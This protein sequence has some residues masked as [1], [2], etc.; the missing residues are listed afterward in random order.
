VSRVNQRGFT[1]LELLVALVVL[2]L[3]VATAYAGLRSA[4][5]SWERAETRIQANE[6]QRAVTRFLRRT[7]AEITPLAHVEQGA[8]TV[9]FEGTNERLVFTSTLPALAAPG[10]VQEMALAVDRDEASGRRGLVLTWQPLDPESE[11]GDFDSPSRT[12]YLLAEGVEN[13]SIDYFGA[14]EEQEDARWHSNWAA[15]RRMPT[16]VRLVV[17]RRQQHWPVIVARV[18]SDSIRFLRGNGRF[19]PGGPSG[20]EPREIDADEDETGDDDQTP[21][22]GNAGEADS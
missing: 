8:W 14:R 20:G 13:L 12:S 7:F 18:R 6:D 15:Q 1:L 4:A 22:P 21:L 3:L 19:S 2:G 17:E 11:P 10:G 9:W 5:N 16:L